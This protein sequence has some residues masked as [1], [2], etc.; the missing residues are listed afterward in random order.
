MAEGEVHSSRAVQ[1]EQLRS[2]VV[3][4]G[5]VLHFGSK[6]NQTEQYLTKLTKMVDGE[7]IPLELAKP[8]G[9]WFGLVP[10]WVKF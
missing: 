4:L 9:F 10:H 5:L 3:W 8:E 2:Q 1:A 7:Y 6:W